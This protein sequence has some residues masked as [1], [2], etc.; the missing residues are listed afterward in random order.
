MLSWGVCVCVY[1]CEM[2]RFTVACVR[3]LIHLSKHNQVA[4]GSICQHV[5]MQQKCVQSCSQNNTWFLPHT[6]THTRK[7]LHKDPHGELWQCAIFIIQMVLWLW[8]PNI[9]VR[10]LQTA[11]RDA[12][13]NSPHWQT[14]VLSQLKCLLKVSLLYLHA[15]EKQLVFYFFLEWRLLLEDSLHFWWHLQNWERQASAHTYPIWAKAEYPYGYSNFS[16][17]TSKKFT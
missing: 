14:S 16:K 9:T 4:S 5:W 8:P 10:S 12:L 17:L 1:V 3:W 2:Q 6:D 13:E 7:Q 15:K 11:E